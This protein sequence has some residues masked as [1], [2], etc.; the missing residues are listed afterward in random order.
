MMLSA[1]TF[2]FLIRIFEGSKD[3]Y[4]K[5]L[6]VYTFYIIVIISG[7]LITLSLGQ[8]KGTIDLVTIREAIFQ[9]VSI[10]TTTGYSS[11]NYDLW[12]PAAKIL[13]MFLMII[14]GCSGSTS[15]GLKIIRVVIA[16]KA[17]FRTIIQTYRPHKTI[18]TRVGSKSLS[19]SFIHNVV[20][21]ILLLFT[22]QGLSVIVLSLLEP[23][24]NL[25]SLFSTIQSSLYNI[26]PG[27]D[28]VG[29]FND[30]SALQDST[31]LFLSFL[32]ILGRLE[33]YA[34]IVLFIPTIWTR[35]S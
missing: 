8:L 32:M 9:T 7:I 22:I 23:N 10:I 2:I 27:F 35:Y 28:A 24:L 33:I 11:A 26:G 34:L 30:F 25:I 5:G 31:K 4:K 16:F 12:L 19:D 13:L 14:G 15:G 6:E 18:I 3:I 29:P 21:Y 17:I 20:L 1:T